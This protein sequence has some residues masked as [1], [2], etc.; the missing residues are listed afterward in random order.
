MR[1]NLSRPEPPVGVMAKTKHIAS[2][3]AKELNISG[4]VPLS[5]NCVSVRGCELKALIVDQ[6]VWPLTETVLQAVRP[7]LYRHRGYIL[8]ME[9]ADP[10]RRVAR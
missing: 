9:R 1:G 5:A 4:A 3:L 6:G 2:S 7:A 10:I 8:Y